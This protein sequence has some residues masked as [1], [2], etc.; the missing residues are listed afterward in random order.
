MGM[1]M[2]IG[3]SFWGRRMGEDSEF[4]YLV[5]GRGFFPGKKI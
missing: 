5:G 4:F 2:G 3:V 1:R